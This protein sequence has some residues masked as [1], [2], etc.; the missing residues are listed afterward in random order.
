M[1]RTKDTPAT[2]SCEDAVGLTAHKAQISGG[3]ALGRRFLLS[4]AP[5]K[6]PFWCYQEMAEKE[7]YIYGFSC[8]I[9]VPHFFCLMDGNCL[10]TC[11]HE[12]PTPP[13]PNGTL[14]TDLIQCY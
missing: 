9:K 12:L 4:W 11:K 5:S 1:P 7:Y 13:A 3:L 6:N 8:D 10:I 2:R 14:P